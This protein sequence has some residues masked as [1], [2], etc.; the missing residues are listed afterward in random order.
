[1]AGPG[2][3]GRPL[4]DGEVLSRAVSVA[5]ELPGRPLA[6]RRR[7]RRR[8]ALAALVSAALAFGAITTSLW[9][10]AV[11]EVSRREAAQ[12]LAL[13][14]LELEDRP[15][16]ALSH[17]LASLEHADSE[18]AR[19]FAVEALWHGASAIV[20]EGGVINIADFSPDGQWI[21]TGGALADQVRLWSRDGGAPKILPGTDAG[22]VRFSPGNRFLAAG[23]RTIARFWSLPRGDQIREVELEGRT[24]F[25]RGERLLSFSAMADG[26]EAVRDWTNPEEVPEIITSLDLSGVGDWHVDASGEWLL[27][28]RGNGVYRSE[29]RDSTADRAKLV[30]M[31][32]ANVVW[33]AAHPT[34]PRVVSGDET[35]E[36]RLWSFA[37]TPGRLERI[38]K[39]KVPS[40]QVDR[41]DSFMVAAAT[42]PHSTPDVAQVWDLKGPPDAD[43]LV[44]RNANVSFLNDF[45]FDP[46]GDWLL[47]AQ[48][49]GILWPLRSKRSH[50]LRRQSPPH[51]QVAFTPDGRSLVSTSDEGAVRV[52][53]LSYREGEKTRKVMEDNTAK[54][55]FYLDVDPAG[56]YALVE[57]RFEP[58][59]FLVPL[60]GSGPRQMPGLTR[61]DGTLGPAVF[62]P[63]GRLVVSAGYLPSLLR[64]WNLE[65]G[66]VRVF[67]T[68][69]PGDQ[70]GTEGKWRDSVVGLAFLA[71]GRLLTIMMRGAIHVWD[72]GDGT[73]EEIRPCAPRNLE[74]PNVLIDKDRRRFV[75]REEGAFTFFDLEKGSARKVTSHGNRV[76]AATLD[77]TGTIVV[78]GSNDGVVR[79]GPV[80]GE[81]PHL[82]YGHTLDVS[83]VAVSPDGKWIASASQDGTIR[84]WPMPEGAPLHTLP[85]EEVLTRLR[86]LTNLRVVPDEGSGTGYGVTVGP[87]P[88]WAKVPEW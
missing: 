59:V 29:L 54:V 43:P 12:I 81:E 6:G 2:P 4:V 37:E 53:P 60:D 44:L 16:A 23:G 69:V 8:I 51:I 17:A 45:G 24:F 68:Q 67:R 65:S 62:S 33:V 73:K 55:G 83:S 50:V 63:D 1:M 47:T 74:D 3:A 57:S 15:T 79:V 20:L 76:T 75:F 71:D 32:E 49:S 52:W 5:G 13:G 84:L 72:L 26:R 35:G 66:D 34:A 7:R 88:G 19:R 39:S 87:F 70:C 61:G 28:G 14:R 42:G 30:G 77:P 40:G 27:T 25:R 38:L 58:R 80:T 22:G 82:L 41:T 36:I 56:K 64:I 31:H 48:Q 18:P 11:L 86:G 21:A 9:R 46:S 85:Y 78:S 10:R